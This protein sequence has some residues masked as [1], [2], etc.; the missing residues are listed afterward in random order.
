MTL[1][2]GFECVCVDD[3]DDWCDAEH[4]DGW[5]CSRDKDQQHDIHVACH[6][7]EDE[8]V[9]AIWTDDDCSKK[10]F[11]LSNQRVVNA[12]LT[13]CGGVALIFDIN[14]S[15]E[16][17]IYSGVGID[18]S[19]VGNDEVAA[20]CTWTIDGE[21]WSDPDEN[22]HDIIGETIW[23]VV[24]LPKEKE[25]HIQTHTETTIEKE[26]IPPR[27]ADMIHRVANGGGTQMQLMESADKLIDE[28]NL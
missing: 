12:Y 19:S 7:E 10:L 14:F 9:L 3:Y 24:Q 1:P 28:F 20:A 15:E 16:P 18:W 11:K 27:I 17:Y 13:R 25:P 26:V 23:P 22:K 8:H 4:P 6:T 21:I 5:M 2:S